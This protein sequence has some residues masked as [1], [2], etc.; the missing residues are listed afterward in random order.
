MYSAQLLKAAIHEAMINSFASGPLLY[1]PLGAQMA[2][3]AITEDFPQSESEFTN[4]R[5][6]LTVSGPT[7]GS[8]ANHSTYASPVLQFTSHAIAQPDAAFLAEYIADWLL[9][10]SRSDLPMQGQNIDWINVVRSP[11]PSRNSKNQLWLSSLD[12]QFHMHVSPNA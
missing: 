2:S 6:T 7:S 11:I 4:N 12:A 3:F 5:A 8:Y 10:V 9:R 1:F